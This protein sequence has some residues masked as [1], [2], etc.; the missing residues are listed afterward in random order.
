M[1]TKLIFIA[2]LACLLSGCSTIATYSDIQ[3][4]QNEQTVLTAETG[5]LADS[6]VKDAEH[7]VET[8]RTTGNKDAIYIAEKHLSETKEIKDRT[9]KEKVIQQ[10]AIKQI[11]AVSDKTAKIEQDNIKKDKE[12]SALKYQK[13]I[14][15]IILSI[16]GLC[17]IVGIWLK[18]KT[19]IKKFLPF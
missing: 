12:I 13:T 10:D 11:K 15:I 8:I 19:F 1:K 18:S 6:T 4:K 2:I 14:F 16:I 17:V 9:D 5:I 7:L 3:Q